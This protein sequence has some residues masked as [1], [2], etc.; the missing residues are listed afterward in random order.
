MKVICPKCHYEF[1][2]RTR[3]PPCEGT[4][5]QN[6]EEASEICEN[7]LSCLYALRSLT[8]ETPGKDFN[9]RDIFYRLKSEGYQCKTHKYWDYHIVQSNLSSLA[10]KKKIEDVPYPDEPL[11]DIHSK[12]NSKMCW[13]VWLRDPRYQEFTIVPFGRYERRVKT[14]R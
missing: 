13:F 12:K 3:A 1:D 8:K 9:T 4:I 6:I 7:E 10:G 11:I 2:V 14:K 5:P